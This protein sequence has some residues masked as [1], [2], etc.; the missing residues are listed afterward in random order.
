MDLGILTALVQDGVTNGAI[1]A[2]LALSLTIVFAV[3]RVIYVPQGE[4]VTYG[5]LS[6]AF[7]Q[8]GIVPSTAYFSVVLG[9]MALGVS[10]WSERG[11]AS[12]VRLSRLALEAVVLPVLILLTTIALAPGKPH[13]VIQM[14]LALAIITPMGSNIYRIAFQPIADASALLL[15]IAAVSVHL[16]LTGLGLFFFGAE[17]FRTVG[18]FED[19]FSLAGLTV[20]GQ[21]MAIALVTILIVAALFTFFEKTLLG[22]ALRATALNRIGAQLSGIAPTLSGRVAFSLAA[23]IGAL[24]GILIGPITTIYYDTGFII[25]LKGFV[26]AIIGGL[27][28]FPLA[29]IAAI[30]V[31]IVEAFSSFWSSQLKEVIVFMTIIPVLLWRSMHQTFVEAEEEE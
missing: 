25:G 11:E 21:A 1:Y 2:L 30:G 13:P 23:F 6:L 10:A 24:S 8:Q 14:L 28:S 5:A 12:F 15:L 7:L 16:V 31:G 17:G 26:A 29:A 19:S 18:M 9:L 3:T 22:K 27:V 20:T 4:F